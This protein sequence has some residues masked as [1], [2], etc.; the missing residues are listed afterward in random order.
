MP[1]PTWAELTRDRCR[2]FCQNLSP[3]LRL[4]APQGSEG[5]V[6]PPA[7]P[8]DTL[9]VEYSPQTE[10]LEETTF[11]SWLS[12]GDLFLSPHLPL[13]YSPSPRLFPDPIS[14]LTLHSCP[15][16]SPSCLKVADELHLGLPVTFNHCVSEWKPPSSP[17]GSAHVSIS[18]QAP[19]A[20]SHPAL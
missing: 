18:I 12:G 8:H 15:K 3:L 7:L 19:P 2:S 5:R 17:D 10:C 4:M 14:S 20:P 9:A 16:P 1:G 6:W 13:L 11:S